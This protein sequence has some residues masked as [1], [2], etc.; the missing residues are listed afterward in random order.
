ML[1]RGQRVRCPT[2]M[3]HEGESGLF[4]CVDLLLSPLLG[5]RFYVGPRLLGRGQGGRVR[6]GPALSKI[7]RVK[8]APARREQPGT[9]AVV[10]SV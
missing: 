2:S 9:Y 6:R 1:R 5:I 4:C 3:L 7:F 8:E 10:P